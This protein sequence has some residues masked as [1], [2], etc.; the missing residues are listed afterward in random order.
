MSRAAKQYEETIGTVFTLSETA[1]VAGVP[2]RT[3]RSW[4]EREKIAVGV[5]NETFGRWMFSVLDIVRL[6]VMHLLT[7]GGVNLDPRFAAPIASQ[8]ASMLYW[9]KR[10][11]A[12]NAAAKEIGLLDSS[13]HGVKYDGHFIYVLMDAGEPIT[14]QSSDKPLRD[15]A[16]E[17]VGF[18]SPFITIP[19]S[20][21]I[22]DVLKRLETLDG[23]TP[24]LAAAKRRLAEIKAPR[25]KK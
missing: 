4:L 20:A 16:E 11:A 18:R 21:I 12:T 17:N 22:K 15:L 19:A 8:V 1:E 23:S 13:T 3:L 2:E 6:R 24:R 7:S 10:T 9:E 5:K 14:V 25:P